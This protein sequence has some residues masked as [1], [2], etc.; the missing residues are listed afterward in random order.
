MTL[1]NFTFKH[2]SQISFLQQR[3]DVLQLCFLSLLR[4]LLLFQFF[5]FLLLLGLELVDDVLE[6]V[7][8]QRAVRLT[9]LAPTTIIEAGYNM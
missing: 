4:F 1:I 2:S 6:G 9:L 8:V 7:L 5:L 3:T